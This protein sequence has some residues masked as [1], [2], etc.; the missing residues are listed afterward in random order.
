MNKP[1]KLYLHKDNFPI[2]KDITTLYD[3]ISR[4]EVVTTN[5]DGTRVGRYIGETVLLQTGGNHYIEICVDSGT[6]TW[7]GIMLSNTP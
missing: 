7:R 1:Q 3:W 5:P 2:D 4:L 6:T